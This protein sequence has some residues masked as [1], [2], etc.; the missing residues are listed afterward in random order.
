MTTRATFTVFRIAAEVVELQQTVAVANRRTAMSDTVLRTSAGVVEL[1]QTLAVTNHRT[2]LDG[3]A[4]RMVA[5]IDQGFFSNI[6]RITDGVSLN[7]ALAFTVSP[8]TTDTFGLSDS[9]VVLSQSYAAA[10]YF[11]DDYVG[12]KRTF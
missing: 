6:K 2:V 12:E 3:T 10:T 9:G 8:A 1:Q 4:L 5:E 11:A 7:D